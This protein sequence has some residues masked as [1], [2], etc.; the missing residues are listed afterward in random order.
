MVNAKKWL[1]KNY[2]KDKRNEITKFTDGGVHNIFDVYNKLEGEL[3][4]TD[5]VNL[6][7]VILADCRITKLNLSNCSKLVKLDCSQNQLSELNLN[8]NTKLTELYC[9]NNQ[10][11]ELNVGNCPSLQLLYCHN[12]LLTNLDLS[13]N[14]QLRFLSIN[15]NNFTKQDLSFLTHL[16]NLQIVNLGNEDAKQIKRGIY[17]HFIGSLQPLQ[18]L[19]NLK[20]LN[21]QNTDISEDLECLP[22][23]LENF[24]FSAELRKEAKVKKIEKM[25]KNYNNDIKKWR[26]ANKKQSEELLKEETSTLSSITN[27]EPSTNEVASWENQTQ[28]LQSQ[29]N[30][31]NDIVCPEKSFNFAHLKKEIQKLKAKE[32]VPQWKNKRAQLNELVIA[33]QNK[34]GNEL[35]SMVDFYLQ[36]YEQIIKQEE[37]DGTFAQNQMKLLQNTLEKKISREELLEIAQLQKEFFYLEKKLNALD[38][39]QEQLETQVELPPKQ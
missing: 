4:L 13:T 33:L 3:D 36:T 34:A 14:L 7:E 26:R 37:E 30:E 6:K 38:L 23:S 17:N 12:N 16:A 27:Y 22:D 31:L 39:S 19:I 35:K 18:A 1:D 9:S 15:D 2:P 5:F 8:K 25:L 21:I 32:L 10:L 28:E 11:R 20:T 29:L 24:T